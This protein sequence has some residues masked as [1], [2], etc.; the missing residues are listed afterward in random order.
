MLDETQTTEHVPIRVLI[1][2]D[3][4]LFRHGLRELLAR[5][6]GIEIVGEADTGRTAVAKSLELRPNVV[7]MDLQM[8]DQGGIEATEEIRRSCP[9]TRMLVLTVSG[10]MGTL[11]RAIVAG[12]AGYVLKDISVESLVAGIRAVH[13][14]D[15]LINSEMAGHLRSIAEPE[16]RNISRRPDGLTDREIRI[17]GEVA[18]GLSDKEIAVKM[19]LSESTIKTHLRSVYRKLKVQNRVQATAYAMKQGLLAEADLATAR[20]VY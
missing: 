8:P 7:L 3:H 11:R 10:D 13:R 15:T 6:D 9:D 17:L 19:F 14:G 12:A 18:R 1:A 2:D 4:E 16:A 20:R 5:F